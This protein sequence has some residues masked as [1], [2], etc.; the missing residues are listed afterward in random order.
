[1]TSPILSLARITSGVRS[2]RL[3]DYYFYY[4]GTSRIVFE[5]KDR[6]VCDKLYVDASI[7]D[8]YL[9]MISECKFDVKILHI[10]NNNYGPA[11]SE[12]IANY[13]NLRILIFKPSI[14]SDPENRL[15]LPMLFLPTLRHFRLY[16]SSI[17]CEDTLK[18]MATLQKS[19]LIRL[20]LSSCN[21]HF[22]DIK[23]SK[24]IDS[25]N[26]I[27]EIFRS[28]I[29]DI[30]IQKCSGLNFG[31]DL[32]KVLADNSFLR[33][34]NYSVKF[35]GSLIGLEYFSRGLSL[36]TS[37]KHLTFNH[38]YGD[39]STIEYILNSLKYNTT[40]THLELE[41]WYFHDHTNDN[42]CVYTLAAEM[43]I[44]NSALTHAKFKFREPGNPNAVF[45][46]LKSNQTLESLELLFGKNKINEQ[47]LADA[48]MHNDSLKELIIEGKIRSN[49]TIKTIVD[50][51]EYNQRLQHLKIDLVYF[52]LSSH[53]GPAIQDMFRGL[54]FNSTFT[55]LEI[56]MFQIPNVKIE[57]ICYIIEH[58]Q[59]LEKFDLWWSY[60]DHDSLKK[61]VDA[62]RKNTSI[63]YALFNLENLT[64]ESYVEV[65]EL[66]KNT[67]TIEILEV[68][69][70]DSRHFSKIV[71]AL[72]FNQSIHTLVLWTGDGD[73]MLQELEDALKFNQ[74]LTH[75]SRKILQ[76]GTSVYQ[77]ITVETS[78]LILNRH[79]KEFS[80]GNKTLIKLAANTYSENY[81]EIPSQEL[82]PEEMYKLLAERMQ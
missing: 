17:R 70:G 59:S 82:I 49:E 15:L 5:L 43:I 6:E 31:P 38:E 35:H 46:A 68:K 23:T 63:K 40:L 79:R 21:F 80:N 14:L 62:H 25:P 81:I 56:P 71:Q 30:S 3:E 58:T 33:K 52:W 39:C 8:H 27:S 29:S 67:Q 65:A 50:S 26:L 72:Q 51:L 61:R 53:Y 47:C 73:F 11:L 36:N 28:Q 64:N 16:D 42:K 32:E 12:M 37:L 76:A 2:L 10:N 9:K 66:V 69:C 19:H 24:S 54:E 34:F 78:Q 4:P 77:P 60:D 7:N 22:Y 57:D 75:V 74:T 55:S 41:V 13:K 1:M 18:L 20:E 48:L 44:C 45:G